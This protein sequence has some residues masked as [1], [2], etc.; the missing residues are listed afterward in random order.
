MS[1][2]YEKLKIDHIAGLTP[3]ESDWFKSWLDLHNFLLSEIQSAILISDAFMG[4]K[5]EK[6]NNDDAA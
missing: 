5:K 4:W 3:E 2:E 1:E 6:E